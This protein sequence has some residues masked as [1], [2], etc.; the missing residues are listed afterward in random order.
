VFLLAVSA[1][2]PD[3]IVKLMEGAMQTH[4]GRSGISRIEVLVLIAVGGLALQLLL[5]ALQAARETAR[6]YQCQSRLNQLGVALHAYHDRNEVFPPAATWG[7]EGLDLPTLD[8][9]NDPTPVHVTR[10]NWIQL[11]L[12]DLNQSALALQF[13]NTAPAADARNRAARTTQVPSLSCPSDPFNRPENFY[14]MPLPDGSNAE[15][16]R[17]NYAI[18]GGSEYVPASFGTLSNPGPTHSLYRYNGTTR[19]FYFLGNGIAGINYSLSLRSFRNGAST[20][21][22]LEEL[23]AGLAP[24]DT[25][26]V[27]A[28]GQVGASITWGHGVTSDTGS[29][30]C[31]KEDADDI[32]QGPELY[33]ELGR[34]FVD[35]ENMHV[36]DHC[37]ENDQAT[38]RSKHPGGV[39]VLM[40]DGAVRFVSDH[41]EPTF[42]HVMH[43]RETPPELLLDRIADEVIASAEV[44][45]E[46]RPGA[47]PAVERSAPEL[48]PDLENSIGQKFARIPAGEFTM[49]TP[50]AGY[51]GPRPP[52]LV[53]HKVRITRALLMGRHEVTQQQFQPVMGS[54]PSGHSIS[55]EYKDR[56]G[57]AETGDWPVENISWA[58][59]VEFCR[60]LSD[61]TSE[62]TAGRRYRLPTEAEW[63]YA[64]R[65]GREGPLPNSDWDSV[66][67]TGEIASKNV[68]SGLV[69]VPKPV[70]SYPANSFGLYD[71]CG[72]VFEWTADFRRLGYY[73]DA[74]ADDPQGPTT[75][76]LRI[77]RGWHWAATG[78]RCKSYL[79]NEPWHGSPFIGFR[80]VCELE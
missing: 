7:S 78:P 24:V 29:P 80:V 46:P 54:N 43:S 71:L 52:D 49:G 2:N 59:A 57:G 45:R 60:R 6:R 56:L 65:S 3:S 20:L 68:P 1:W 17:G 19:E 23:R 4:T 38:A 11:L 12:P 10:Q 15:F 22:A 79:A 74:P 34:E 62:S 35:G 61:S 28:L 58:D 37:D 73:K 53:P 33:R 47:Q 48:P 5:P 32:R 69:L 31:S 8:S 27:W 9:H 18:N 75:G 51:A 50:D 64:C 41:V 63:E 21:V 13:D 42:W 55:G 67:I 70:E 14:R 44:S 16:A 72:N 39:L 66:E 26:G 76:Y 77:I 40:L 36:C 30:N 25:R